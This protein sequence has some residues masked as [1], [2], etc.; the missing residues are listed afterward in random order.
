MK[1]PQVIARNP[2]LK[3]NENETRKNVSL[4][5]KYIFIVQKTAD[6]FVHFLHGKNIHDRP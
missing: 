2:S 5:R 3:L 6:F 4:T 1:E